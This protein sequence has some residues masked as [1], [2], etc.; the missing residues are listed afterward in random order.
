M[1][2]DLRQFP[3]FGLN[4]FETY[5]FNTS[6]D[7]T[8]KLSAEEG[9]QLSRPRQHYC[10]STPT[11]IES[12]SFVS[13]T[14]LI[15][16]TGIAD[17]TICAHFA[18]KLYP[19]LLFPKTGFHSDKTGALQSLEKLGTELACCC[20]RTSDKYDYTIGVWLILHAQEIL[21][22]CV[23]LLASELVTLRAK[24]FSMHLFRF[25]INPGDLYFRVVLPRGLLLVKPMK[26]RN[27]SHIVLTFYFSSLF[28]F[29]LL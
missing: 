14:L 2:S 12:H 8:D 10:N 27:S 25:L 11:S 15:C 19:R 20:T 17:S 7:G 13:V 29:R 21:H 28:P 18:N 24:L 6:I 3:Y 4:V 9:I 23:T 26:K 5:V 1:K 22:N 16:W